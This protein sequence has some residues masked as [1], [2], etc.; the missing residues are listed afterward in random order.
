[1][2]CT[3]QSQQRALD[4]YWLKIVADPDDTSGRCMAGKLN[5]GTTTQAWEAAYLTQ[6][7]KNVGIL[8]F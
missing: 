7:N 6:R 8:F 2:T 4:E 3:V 5:I 1:M